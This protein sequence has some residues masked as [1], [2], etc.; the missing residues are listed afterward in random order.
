M[1]K[2]LRLI[3]A[4]IGILGI[5]GNSAIAAWT[6]LVSSGDFTGINTDLTTIATGVVTL[7]L[8]LVG[9]GFIVKGMLH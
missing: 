1:K 5:L 9:I 7:A 2:L 8:V 3:L 6:P 4:A